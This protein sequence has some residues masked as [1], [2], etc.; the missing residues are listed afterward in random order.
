MVWLEG[1]SLDLRIGGIGFALSL[2]ATLVISNKWNC[3]KSA[4]YLY[5]LAVWHIKFDT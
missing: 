2:S 5:C 1:K 3:W 4:S